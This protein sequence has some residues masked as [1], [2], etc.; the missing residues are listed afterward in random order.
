MRKDLG[1][2]AVPVRLMFRAP[3]NPYDD[4]GKGGGGS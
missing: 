2:G 1:F 4:N 3:K